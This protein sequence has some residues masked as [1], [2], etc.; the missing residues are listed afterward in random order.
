MK[1]LFAVVCLCVALVARAQSYDGQTRLLSLPSLLVSG[2]TYTNIV[3]RLNAVELVSNGTPPVA[4]ANYD[5]LSRVLALPKVAISGVEYLHVQV[6]LIDVEVVSA[7]ASPSRIYV[8]LVAHNEDTATGNNPDCLAF[9]S[10]ATSL[11]DAN[12][13]AL[14]AIVRTVHEKKATFNFQSDV[15]YLNLV[16]ARETPGNNVLRRL[17]NS[18]AGTLEI[19]AHAHEGVQK[20]YA[21]VANLVERVA[22]VR[23]GIVGG[24]T[25]VT[26]RPDA[27]SPDWEKFRRPLAPT[28]G[29]GSAFNATV[30]TLGASAGHVCDPDA[31]GIWRPTSISNFFTDDPNQSLITIGTGYAAKGLTEAASAIG[32]LVDDLKAGRLE[33]N[34]MY[35]ASVTLPHCNMHLTGSGATATDVATFIDAVNALDDSSDFIRWATFTQMTDIWKSS[36][37]KNPSTWR[38]P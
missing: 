36:Y 15:E 7:G 27:A 17:A 29:F 9:F 30:L 37:G 28:S 25:A 22:G 12:S 6:R 21:D 19:D 2:T 34:R 3:L 20:N 32:R 26:C 24:F 35:T 4:S 5:L 10:A 38:G 31:A 23:N 13:A 8:N 11:Y 33:Q 18:Y 1:Y 16:L 14:E